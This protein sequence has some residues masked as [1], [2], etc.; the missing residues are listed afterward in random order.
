MR[1][2]ARSRR[3]VLATAVLAGASF[4][5]AAL[6]GAHGGDPELVHACVKNAG[7]A[8]RL[9]DAADACGAD[10]RA[11]DWRF[12]GPAGPAGPRG[13]A[14]PAGAAGPRG[15]QGPT[16]AS[17]GTAPLTEATGTTASNGT[18][19]KEL[20]VDCPAGQLPLSGGHSHTSSFPVYVLVSEAT[21]AG[22]RAVV[23]A[24]HGS[25]W[26]L[27]LRV[28]CT[29]ALT[30]PPPVPL[31][32]VL[33]RAEICPLA[34]GPS[35]FNAAEAAR[36][37]LPWLVRNPVSGAR[38]TVELVCEACRG[39][40]ARTAGVQRFVLDR[41]VLRRAPKGALKVALRLTRSDVRRLRPRGRTRA[42]VVVTVRSNSRTTRRSR[43][44]LY[45]KR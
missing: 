13:A 38:V 36:S 42:R 20:S 14:G 26:A 44:T 34:C 4:G 28:L 2:L 41:R 7:G 15:P 43:S 22:W 39:V 40:R 23:K 8:V 9:V 29:P 33:P 30:A 6:G 10:E 24:T 37:S 45:L 5:G 1:L 17:G 3:V 27:R 31:V 18:T 32:E 21:A 19:V 11:V 12:S 35:L 25:A 16:G